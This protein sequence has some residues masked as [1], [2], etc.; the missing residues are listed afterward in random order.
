MRSTVKWSSATQYYAYGVSAEAPG[1]PPFYTSADIRGTNISHSGEVFDGAFC[2]T[3]TNTACNTAS[4]N[5]CSKDPV[6][7]GGCGTGGTADNYYYA[8]TWHW[9]QDP[10]W[11]V[12]QTYTATTAGRANSYCYQNMNCF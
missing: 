10:D 12:Y 6:A 8:T 1:S 2:R 3:W 4:I 11:V 9:W 5:P 7:I